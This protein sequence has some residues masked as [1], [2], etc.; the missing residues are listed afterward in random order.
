FL[1][2]TK[3]RCYRLRTCNFF[4]NVGYLPLAFRSSQFL[5]LV[6]SCPLSLSFVFQYIFKKKEA[7]FWKTASYVNDFKIK[8]IP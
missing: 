3:V 7:A 4:R 8:L 5:L 6:D 2:R 1:E